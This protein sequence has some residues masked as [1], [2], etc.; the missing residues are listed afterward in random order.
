M[1]EAAAAVFSERGLD[2]GV[3]EIAQRAGVGRGTLFRNFPCK[4][5][6]IAAIVV[7]RMRDAVRAGRELLHGDAGADAVFGFIADIAGRQQVDRA[8][9]EAVADEFLANPEIRAAHAEVIKV[10]DE[11]LDAAKRDGSVRPDV[12]A[13]DVLMML[14]GACA[15]SAAFGETKP[16][17]LE[18]HLDLVRAAISTPAHPQ[19]LRGTAPTLADLEGVL[20]KSPSSA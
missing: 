1:L 13:L 19:P 3:G 11:L 4:Q 18:R 8:L 2:V 20:G 12:G 6:L 9:F 17:I 7:E 15:A 10:V 14:K 5:D 16:D